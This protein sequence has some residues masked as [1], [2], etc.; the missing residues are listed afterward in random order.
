MAAAAVCP[1]VGTT[2]TVLPPNHPDF[3]ESEPGLVCPVTKA[4]TDH[5]QNLAKHPAVPGA[6]ANKAGE[7]PALQKI[8]NEPAQKAMDE[9]VCPVVGTVTSVLPP[10]HP[11]LKDA[12]EDDVC[13]KTNAKLSHHVGKIHQHPSVEAAKSGA[14]C[15]VVGRA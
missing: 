12:K 2:N 10:D 1:V 3:D 8:V 14:V 5:H 6:K 7:C 9:N 11:S 4:S 15:P 13:P